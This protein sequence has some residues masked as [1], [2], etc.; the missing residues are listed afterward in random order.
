MREI[1]FR[2]IARN[3]HTGVIHTAIYGIN[4]IEERPLHKLSDMFSDNYMQLGRVE[5]TGLKDKN[6]VEIYEGDIVEMN[7]SLIASTRLDITG[8]VKM[9]EGGWNVDSGTEL[10]NL[11]SEVQERLIV[12]NIYE[13]PELLEGG[14]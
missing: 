13:N 4:R 9:L 7:C 14:Y 8:E 10:K 6:G 5:Y 3:K 11:W 1:K 12:G 2:Y